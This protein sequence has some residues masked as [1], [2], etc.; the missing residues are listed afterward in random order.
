MEIV[1]QKDREFSEILSK[2]KR[3]GKPEENTYVDQM[4]K[5]W[6]LN[7]YEDHPGYPKS[8]FHKY[9]QNIHAK[10]RNDKIFND[11]V[12]QSCFSK[13]RDSVRDDI[14]NLAEITLPTKPSDTGNLE[15]TLWIKVGARAMHNKSIDVKDGLTNAWF[16][17]VT[18]SMTRALKSR[19][20]YLQK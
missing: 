19:Y 11:I 17:L 18:H 1:V 14:T 3:V 2:I 12:G 13:V 15:E 5:G 10:C 4:L 7:I 16:G 20:T 9:A 6:E 8:V